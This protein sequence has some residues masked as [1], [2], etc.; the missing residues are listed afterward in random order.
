VLLVVDLTVR[1]KKAKIQHLI[2]Q[3]NPQAINAPA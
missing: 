1:M 3:P 2:P